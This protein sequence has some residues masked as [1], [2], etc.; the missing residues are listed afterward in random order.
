MDLPTLIDLA[1][2]RGLHLLDN[3]AARIFT[4]MRLVVAGCEYRQL[5][6]S[7]AMSRGARQRLPKG[8]K[9]PGTM[10]VYFWHDKRYY[11]VRDFIFTQGWSLPHFD[12]FRLF[13]FLDTHVFIVNQ[14]DL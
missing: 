10:P 11:D 4:A 13:K 14:G 8:K 6:A 12:G 1:E 7:A 3:E 9:A 2:Q 5:E